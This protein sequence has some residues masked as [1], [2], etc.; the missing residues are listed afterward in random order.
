MFIQNLMMLKTQN[1]IRP[2]YKVCFLFLN[3]PDSSAGV[4]GA[5]SQLKKF[6]EEGKFSFFRVIKFEIT[7]NR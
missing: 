1:V 6:F 7:W 5:E 4:S 3:Y 2:D